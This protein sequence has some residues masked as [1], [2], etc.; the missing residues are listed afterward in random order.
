MLTT[1]GARAKIN[2]VI[3]MRKKFCGADCA[4]GV[5]KK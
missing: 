4:E 3:K 2:V 1:F 5:T